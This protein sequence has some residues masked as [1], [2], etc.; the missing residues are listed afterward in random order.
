[1]LKVDRNKIFEMGWLDV[2]DAYR[3]QGWNVV[4]DRPGYC[5]SYEA[6]FIFTRGKK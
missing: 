5:E 1:V 3:A 4:Y 2:E 6:S